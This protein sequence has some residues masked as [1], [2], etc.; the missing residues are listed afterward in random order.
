MNPKLLSGHLSANWIGVSS[1]KS[2]GFDDL[3]YV[4]RDPTRQYKRMDILL[5]YLSVN[6]QHFVRDADGEIALRR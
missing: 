4:K 5:L 1:G 3:A 2:A 6:G